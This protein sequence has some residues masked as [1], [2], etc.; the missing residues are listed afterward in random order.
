MEIWEYFYLVIVVVLC[1]IQIYIPDPQEI[2][3]K[4]EKKVDKYN[5]YVDVHINL[6]QQLSD[7]SSIW[8]RNFTL[9]YIKEEYLIYAHNRAIVCIFHIF[10]GSY[11]ERAPSAESIQLNICKYLLDIPTI[12]IVEGSHST[13]I[14]LYLCP[15][16][17]TNYTL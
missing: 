1:G 10:A 13:H 17:C 8:R 7:L 2:L 3:F 9:L 16:S 4:M 15:N 14:P 11:V 5:I 6:N 12:Y